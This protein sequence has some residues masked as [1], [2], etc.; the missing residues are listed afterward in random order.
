MPKKRSALL[1][2]IL[3]LMT[4]GMGQIYNGQPKRGVVLFAA[5]Y[6]VL[7]AL[8]RSGLP[9]HFSGMM[10]VIG[11]G[12]LSLG[13][14]M[15]DAAAGARKAKTILLRRYNRW[16]VYLLPTF[17]WMVLSAGAEIATSHGLANLMLGME[18]FKLPSRSM[19]PTLH[20]EDLFLVDIASY[21]S[22]PVKRGDVI[23]F[24]YPLDS[25]TTFVKRV[26]AVGGDVLEIKDGVLLINQAPVPEAYVSS[27][28]KA[29][30]F[31]PV[32]VPPGNVFVLGDNRDNSVDSREWGFVPSETI[33]GRALY[34]FWAADLGRIG[35]EIR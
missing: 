13:L 16:Y 19:E 26:A 28:K 17:L 31:G 30:V 35:K 21:R 9:H 6:L 18:S 25:R 11:V 5:Y 22:H 29:E 27:S 15:G 7:I 1:A 20:L 34:L 32:T 8:F 33:L 23:V 3:S 24:P 2:A 4:P 12:I 10:G 14:I